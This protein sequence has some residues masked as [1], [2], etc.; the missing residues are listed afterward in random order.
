[1]KKNTIEYWLHRANE[2]NRPWAGLAI[3]RAEEDKHYDREW[4]CHSYSQALVWA[5]DWDKTPEG[6]EFWSK[7]FQEET[8]DQ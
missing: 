7:I 1:M 4:P 6:S 2:M 3:K 8:K 5:F